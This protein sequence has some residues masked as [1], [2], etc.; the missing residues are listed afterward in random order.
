MP[1]EEWKCQKRVANGDAYRTANGIVAKRVSPP[2]SKNP[3]YQVDR[4]K[5]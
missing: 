5:L 4:D 1:T 3:L 2:N